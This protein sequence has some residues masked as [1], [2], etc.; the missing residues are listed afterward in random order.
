MEFIDPLFLP[1]VGIAPMLPKSSLEKVVPAL[2]EAQREPS[3]VPVV[4]P[5]RD[6]VWEESSAALLRSYLRAI[7]KDG[8][9]RM[10][11]GIGVL[12]AFLAAYFA[13]IA[14]H[15]IA[16]LWLA[17]L[18]AFVFSGY[19]VWKHD[20]KAFR[21]EIRQINVSHAEKLNQL[22]NQIQTLQDAKQIKLTAFFVDIDS[23]QPY[24]YKMNRYGILELQ[25]REGVEIEAIIRILNEGA[26]PTKIHNLCLIVEIEEAGEEERERYTAP[27]P[28]EKDG[29]QNAEFDLNGF[30]RLVSNHPDSIIPKLGKQVVKQG[31]PL[32]GYVRFKVPG[33]Y[34]DGFPEHGPWSIYITL[35]V[36]DDTGQRHFIPMQ[37]GSPPR[38]SKRLKD[39]IHRNRG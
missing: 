28:E 31:R 14:N 18:I 26:V 9:A 3:T 25:K 27:H 11:G 10:S 7:W 32:E 5:E 35:G 24:P 4:S 19:R 17:A 33:M 13:F 34:A 16:V 8:V 1:K 37:W 2:P 21:D 22:E 15:S 20:R 36:D 23:G 38:P 29:E 30:L 39:G 6:L 12:L